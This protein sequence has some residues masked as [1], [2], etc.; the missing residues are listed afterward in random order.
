MNGYSHSPAQ[1]GVTLAGVNPPLPDL[2]ARLT[3]RERLRR[4][5]RVV[6]SMGVLF[7][8][9]SNLGAV[10]AIGDAVFTPALL[11]AMADE[12]GDDPNF[13]PALRDRPRLGPLDLPA[14]RAKPAGTLAHAF[15]Q[16]LDR[17]GLDADDI[18][19]HP[20]RDATSYA[21]AHLLETHDIWHTV[22]DFDADV[23][24]ELGLHGFYLAQMPTRLAPLMLGG[25]IIQTLKHPYAE[26]DA[27]MRAI[28]R[29]WLMGKRA[30]PLFGVRWTE[31]WDTPIA[32][33]RAHFRVDPASVD[34][35][36]PPLR[37]SSA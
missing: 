18:P 19:I 23:A 21:R 11:K 9:P 8:K 32:E 22:A 2:S 20:A 4:V 16:H 27:R 24:G 15:V 10:V 14:L 37:P 17:N 33:V 7:R 3:R 36:M 26:G 25:G 35:F 12:I 30:R 5:L 29:G 28:V 6:Y 31:L 13:A 34:A 1:N